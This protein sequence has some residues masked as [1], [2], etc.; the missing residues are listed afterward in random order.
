MA[1]TPEE[2]Q[3]MKDEI[4]NMKSKMDDMTG[5]GLKNQV[6]EMSETMAKINARFEAE[7]KAKEDAV[8]AEKATLE[9]TVA[10]AGLMTAEEA[11][12]APVEALRVLANAAS[13]AAAAPI[14]G[15][16]INRKAPTDLAAMFPSEA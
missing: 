12:A 15:H 6:K 11:K 10:N 13:K 7:D 4:A 14:V 16:F 2:A 8:T 1:L 5:E 9:E 3:A